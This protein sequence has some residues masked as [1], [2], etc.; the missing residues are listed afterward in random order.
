M[1]C[2]L[3]CWEKNGGVTS[4][5]NTLWTDIHSYK[6]NLRLR[7]HQHPP[8][9]TIMCLN[10]RHLVMTIKYK[11]EIS[12][13]TVLIAHYQYTTSSNTAD[14]DIIGTIEFKILS[15]V[16]TFSK[17]VWSKSHH[18]TYLE[19]ITRLLLSKIVTTSNNSKGRNDFFMVL[20]LIGHAVV[21]HVWLHSNDMILQKNSCC[22]GKSL[23]TTHMKAG[24]QLA[25]VTVE[26]PSVVASAGMPTWHY[27]QSKAR[28]SIQ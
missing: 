27:T 22:Y 14:A 12:W 19:N 4:T 15:S 26:T 24:S 6:H 20:W 16:P 2:S 23:K 1:K 17:W 7:A 18:G 25:T 8:T 5:V 21:A 3:V 28:S 11:T 9:C 13:H 10:L